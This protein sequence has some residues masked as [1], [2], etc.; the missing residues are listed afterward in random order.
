M[1]HMEQLHYNIQDNENDYVLSER[2]RE[3]EKNNR[4]GKERQ[5]NKYIVSLGF[6]T[7]VPPKE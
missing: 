1:G 4:R 5:K 6:I 3:K 7:Y 2:K